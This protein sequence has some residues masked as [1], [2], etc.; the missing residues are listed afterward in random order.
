MLI[1][2]L[3]VMGCTVSVSLFAYLWSERTYVSQ[4]SDMSLNYFQSSNNRLT[5]FLHYTEETF[6][7]IANHPTIVQA[8]SEPYFSL[9]ASQLLGSL[10]L[11]SNLDIIDVKLYSASGFVYSVAKSLSTQPFELFKSTE[12]VRG[13]LE[14]PDEKY[15]WISRTQAPD[16]SGDGSADNVFSYLLKVEEPGRMLGT[17]VVDFDYHEL[18]TFFH[19]G[20]PLFNENKLLLIAGSQSLYTPSNNA[21]PELTSEEIG[22]IQSG[23]EG[24]FIAANG[25]QLVIYSPIVDSSTRM[26]VLIPLREA[27][28]QLSNLKWTL[29]SF[30]LVYCVLVVYLAYLLRNSIVQPLIHLYGTID[31]WNK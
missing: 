7:M 16:G 3:A 31:N 15:L 24:R 22:S 4:Y 26:A 12:P 6:K 8:M 28:S 18:F 27:S 19:T 11:D 20:N 29:I 13:F 25:K 9:D 14:R 5:Q 2:L 10:V 1:F 17:L 23:N 21:L 30:V